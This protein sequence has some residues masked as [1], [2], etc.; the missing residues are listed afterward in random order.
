MQYFWSH[1][2]TT[3]PKAYFDTQTSDW[4]WPLDGFVA[5][6]SLY[7]FLEQMHSQGTG[8]FGF[9]YTGVVL[10]TIS[11]Y[12]DSPDKWTVQYQPV[13]TGNTVVPGAAAV[14]QQGASGNPFPA[15]PNGAAYVY[16]FTWA[17]ATSGATYTGLTRIPLSKLGSASLLAGNWQYLTTGNLW[18]SWTASNVLP[19]NAQHVMDAGYTEFT[20]KYHAVAGQSGKWLAVMPSST[21]MDK[22]GVYRVA[23]SIAG[24]WTAETTLYTY[25]EM[26][27]TN[28]SYTANVFCYADKEH[29]ELEQGNSLVFT[30]ACNSMQLPEVLANTKLYH[31][32]PV[33][34]QLPFNQ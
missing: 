16:L 9:D 3:A 13:L 1:M 14:M 34:V 23:D 6:G 22:R 4:Y 7:I 15:D 30:Y 21:F 17:K 2:G 33:T 10:A 8:A 20:V 32:V 18:A 31:P 24:P 26:Q 25:P 5:N 28:S 19:D 29:T 11:N 12:S 27:S